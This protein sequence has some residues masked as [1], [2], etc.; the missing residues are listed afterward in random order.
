MQD[1]S[2]RITVDKGI[3]ASPISAGQT[4]Q[5]FDMGLWRATRSTTLSTS[6]PN[7]LQKGSLLPYNECELYNAAASSGRSRDR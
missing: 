4:I 3:I 2:P 1:Y 5:V 7:R 6:K